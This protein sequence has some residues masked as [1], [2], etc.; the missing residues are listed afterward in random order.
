MLSKAQLS[1]QEVR[2]QHEGPFRRE[3]MAI[4]IG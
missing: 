4:F 1:P 3:A 2:I